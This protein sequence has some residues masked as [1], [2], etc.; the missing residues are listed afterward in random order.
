MR[1]A[2]AW[3]VPQTN[4]G[5]KQDREEADDVG[6]IQGPQRRENKEAGSW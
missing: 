5:Q 2:L 6:Y 3:G 1:R 4:L